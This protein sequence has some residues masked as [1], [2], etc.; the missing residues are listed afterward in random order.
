[1]ESMRV[2]L[3]NDILE[4]DGESFHHHPNGVGLIA[5][6][7]FA[8]VTTYIAPEIIAYGRAVVPQF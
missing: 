3:D 1:M 5:K 8:A 4:I 7:A 6:A 2:S